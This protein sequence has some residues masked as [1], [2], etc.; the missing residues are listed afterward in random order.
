MTSGGGDG[1][2]QNFGPICITIPKMNQIGDKVRK[3]EDYDGPISL[4]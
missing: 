3:Q 1:T 2:A 4:T